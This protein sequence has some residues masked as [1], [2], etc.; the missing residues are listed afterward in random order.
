MGARDMAD[1]LKICVICGEDCAGRPRIKDPKGHYYHKSCHEQA[2]LEQ[3]ARRAAVEPD[4]APSTV[5]EPESVSL[6]SE[7]LDET[8]ETGLAQSCPACGQPL[9]ADSVLCTN[10][11]HSQQSGQLGTKLGEPAKDRSQISG[12]LR[13]LLVHPLTL[14]AAYLLVYVLLLIGVRMSPGNS[15]VF[16]LWLVWHLIIT[17]PVSLMVWVFAF[18]AGL[19]TGLLVVI[20]PPFVLYFIY[21]TPQS[22]LVRYL[23]TV[24]LLVQVLAWLVDPMSTWETV[25]TDAAGDEGGRGAIADR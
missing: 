16:A 1:S 23:F 5:D 3:E 8:P 4:P 15:G 24:V 7:I 19:F 22:A 10:C 14:S 2:K 20:F 6:L 11:G 25:L 9:P 13:A 21:L 18:R 17:L 12:Q